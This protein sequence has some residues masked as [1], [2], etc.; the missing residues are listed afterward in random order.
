MKYKTVLFCLLG[1]FLLSVVVIFLPTLLEPD[2]Y[3]NYEEGVTIEIN[4]LSGSDL[5]NLNF[6]YGYAENTAYKEIGN[7]ERFKPENTSII[8]TKKN[9]ILN[10]EG[11]DISIYM[12]YKLLNGFEIQENLLYFNP[13]QPNKIVLIIDIKQID[14]YGNIE[15]DI[16]GFDGVQSFPYSSE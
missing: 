9:K 14:N 2:I 15:Y 5:A 6:S 13:P 12:N 11:R 7:I 1:F 16:R 10:N 4:N 8:K 3:K